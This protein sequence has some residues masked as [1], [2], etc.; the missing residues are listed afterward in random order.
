MDSETRRRKQQAL[1]LELVEKKIRQ[2]A[3]Q[4]YQER[5]PSAGS[6]LED[7]VRAESEVLAS[8]TLA[9]LYWRQRLCDERLCSADTL[10][11]TADQ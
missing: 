7:W 10:V 8:T 5:E 11:R 2:R 4:L 3:Q 1:L 9:P 6:P